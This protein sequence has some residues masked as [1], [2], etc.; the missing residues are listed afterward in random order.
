M[1]FPLSGL[2]SACRSF[3]IVP[4]TVFSGEA[5]HRGYAPERADRIFASV[6][7]DEASRSAFFPQILSCRKSKATPEN[8][9]RFASLYSVIYLSE[10][11]FF[12]LEN[13]DAAAAIALI[14]SA[15]VITAEVVS[16]VPGAFTSGA[17]FAGVVSAVFGVSFFVTVSASA[18]SCD[19]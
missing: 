14:R 13:T 7:C 15:A 12:L 11:F 9:S 8:G 1:P 16:P 19:A 2:R 17:S 5:I 10:C 3:L 18:I 4:R 6:T